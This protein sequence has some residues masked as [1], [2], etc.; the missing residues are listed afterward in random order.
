MYRFVIENYIAADRSLFFHIAKSNRMFFFSFLALLCLRQK[1]K[2]TTIS[3][4]KNE[5]R[6]IPFCLWRLDRLEPQNRFALNQAS[7]TF[8]AIA[9]LTIEMQIQ[10]AHFLVQIRAIAVALSF[11]RIPFS[12]EKN[13]RI[14][15]ENSFYILHDTLVPIRTSTTPLLVLKIMIFFNMA[16]QPIFSLL[17]SFWT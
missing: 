10:D 14:S 9:H 3:C 7:R 8:A 5:F 12:N 13:I 1:L 16:L 2:I 6:Y 11:L 4:F 17:S 15:S